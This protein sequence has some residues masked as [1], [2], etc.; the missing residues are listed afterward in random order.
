MISCL[1]DRLTR[2]DYYS[3]IIFSKLPHPI[4]STFYRDSQAVNVHARVLYTASGLSVSKFCNRPLKLGLSIYL[5]TQLQVEVE[6]Q[7]L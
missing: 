2:H 6:I 4:G 5:I 3:H 7:G 1:Q